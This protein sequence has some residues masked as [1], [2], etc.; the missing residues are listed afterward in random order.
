[1]ESDRKQVAPPTRHRRLAYPV[2]G[3]KPWVI[4]CL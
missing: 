3:I 4:L 1:V 2:S